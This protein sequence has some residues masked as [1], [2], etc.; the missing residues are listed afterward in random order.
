MA[1]FKS[2]HFFYSLMTC[3]ALSMTACSTTP[4]LNKA[5]ELQAT[6]DNSTSNPLKILTSTRWEL[7]QQMDG[8]TTSINPE[9][10]PA[11]QFEA[12][13]QRFSGNDGCNRMVG[14]Y[15][16]DM[17][18]LKFGQVAGTKMACIPGTDTLSRHFTDGL[19]HT[20]AYR[21]EGEYLIL[22]NKDGDK[23]LTLRKAG[24]AEPD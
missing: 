24:S 7:I 19:G 18:S 1:F 2:T 6:S 17:T 12:N 9:L 13:T 20:T 16:A 14:S 11:L 8:S 15:Q 3:A 22:L 4:T 21:F 5:G 23:L 10:R